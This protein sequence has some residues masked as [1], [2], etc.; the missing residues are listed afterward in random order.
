MARARNWGWLLGM[1]LWGGWTAVT[2]AAS[3]G[4]KTTTPAETANQPNA[5]VPVTS[6]MSQKPKSRIK[7][8]A[9]L[10]KWWDDFFEEEKEHKLPTPTDQPN[11]PIPGGTPTGSFR[12]LP[13]QR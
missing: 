6:F 11:R 8:G 7:V 13:T 5:Y 4:V 3:G 1:A 2:I 9:L 10:R 12:A